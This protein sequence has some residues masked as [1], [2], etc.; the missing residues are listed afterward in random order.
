[1]DMWDYHIRLRALAVLL[2]LISYVPYVLSISK[3]ETKPHTISRLI[4]ALS[5]GLWFAVQLQQ[6]MWRW[7]TMLWAAFLFDV[8]VLIRSL[9]I[10]N[11]NFTKLDLTSLWL[12]LLALWLRLMTDD[13][14][15]SVVLISIADTL[16]FYPTF[17]KSYNDPSSE[18]LSFWIL[19]SSSFVVWMLA[20]PFITPIAV[21]YPSVVLFWEVLLILFLLYRKHTIKKSQTIDA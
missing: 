11:F 1:M 10:W 13:P 2:I 18:S 15:W 17:S 3:W 9:K 6:W 12:A 20:L 4:W 7:A 21:L 8:S 19:D 16:W 14:R 5:M